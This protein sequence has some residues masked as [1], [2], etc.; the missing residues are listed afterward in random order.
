[1]AAAGGAGG[2]AD[3]AARRLDGRG[4]GGAVQRPAWPGYIYIYIYIY[5]YRYIYIYI[6]I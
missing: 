2:D 5:I 1:M 6:D 3:P 4:G